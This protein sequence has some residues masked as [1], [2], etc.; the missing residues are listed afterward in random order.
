MIAFISDIHANIPA[1]EAVFADIARLGNVERVLCLGDVIGYGPRPIEA[2]EMVA[3]RCKLVLMGNHEHAVLNGAYGF[4]A[5]AKRAV[6]WTREQL[7]EVGPGH[8]RKALWKLLEDLPVRHQIDD[9]LLV[10]GS[11][12]DPVME[13]VL[14]SDLWDGSDPEKMEQIF[15]A[16]Q[17]LCFVGHTHR[18]GVFTADR[19]FLPAAELPDG[20]DISD[21][22]KYLV[23]IGSVGQPRDRDNRAC[24]LIFSGDAVYWRRVT[25][26]IDT[27]AS[28]VRAIAALDNRFADRLFRGE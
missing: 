11:P 19:C 10:H 23:N 14:E 18:P 12:R 9:L 5:A 17:R 22:S 24:Y 27:T 25:Y 7:Q 21:G 15:A 13:Y 28:Q 6:D 2:L 8:R 20:F 4:H 3:A 16:F 26:D 1:L